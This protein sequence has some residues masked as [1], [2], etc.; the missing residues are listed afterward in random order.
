MLA[1]TA[2][3]AIVIGRCSSKSPAHVWSST[4]L[5]VCGVVLLSAAAQADSREALQKAAA[6]VQQGRLDE[7][8]RQAQLALADP[9]TRAVA[10]SVLGAIRVQQKRLDDSVRLLQKALTLEPRLLG[11]HLSLAQ[12]Y[13]LQGKSAR[14]TELYTRVLEL[15]PTNATARVALARAEM[16][17]GNYQ[18]SLALAE[19]VLPAFTQSPE[20]LFVLATDWLKTGKRTE[21][22]GLIDHWA[23][24]EGVPPEWSMKFALAFVEDGAVREGIQILDRVRQTGP[25]TFELAFNLAGAY[26]LNGEPARALDAYD[27]A[28]SLQPESL[29]GAAA[30]RSPRRAAAAARAIAVLLDAGKEARAGRLQRSCSGFGRVC[31]KMDLL[32]DAEPAL[33]RAAALKPGEL[34]YQYTLAV[35]KVGKRQFEAAQGLLEPLV[36]ARP[37]DAQL[38]YAL[39]SVLY[40]QGRL[41]T[42]RRTCARAFV[43][44]PTSSGRITT[45]R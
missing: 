36:R 25:L 26:L 17:K 28:I 2:T 4:A 10:Y 1:R 40:T 45:S 16:E 12:V 27:A 35:A 39:G 31:L 43:C 15:D 21:A 30:G 37:D 20:G 6:L 44:R 5:L 32:E 8:D 13:T 3:A 42:P 33:A 19:P 18:R 23:R 38:Q 7:A 9:E 24:L 14:A 41:P 34:S 29:P 11:A 22:L